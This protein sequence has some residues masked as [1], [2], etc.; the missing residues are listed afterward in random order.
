M[1]ESC[2][3]GR[4]II[5]GVLGLSLGEL[6]LLLEGVNLLPVFEDFLFFLREI[7]SLGDYRKYSTLRLHEELGSI[8]N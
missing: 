1:R 7:R 8:E 6:Q 5:E 2:S 3:E 4:P